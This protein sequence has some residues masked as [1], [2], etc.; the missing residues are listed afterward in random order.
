MDAV[1]QLKLMEVDEKTYRDV[2]QLHV[3]QQ[4]GLM[5]RQ[6]L[7]DRFEFEQQAILDQNIKPKWLF[8]DKALVFDFDNALVDCGHLAQAEFADEAL[9][10]NAFKEA[11]PLKTMDLD[12][13]TDGRMA[14]LIRFLE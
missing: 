7:L 5:D 14:Q 6:D 2:Q 11:R 10:I 4:L 8:E 13:C 1:H 9:L 12:G 3:T